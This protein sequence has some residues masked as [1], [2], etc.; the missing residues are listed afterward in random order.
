MPMIDVSVALTSLMLVDNF[1]V[2]RRTQ[3]VNEYGE[4]IITP[5]SLGTAYGTVNTASDNDL[6]R[7]ADDQIQNKMISVVTKFMLRGVWAGGQP[8]ILVWP[9]N[10]NGDNFIVVRIEDYSQIG[11]GFIQAICASIDTID[12]APVGEV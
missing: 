9:N 3:S 1:Q 4:V 12:F 11:P 7:V 5:T 10:A 6:K 2:I 8:D